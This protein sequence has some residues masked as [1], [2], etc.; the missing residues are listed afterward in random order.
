MERG[1]KLV[2]KGTLAI[3]DVKLF[4]DY[5]VIDAERR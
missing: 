5:S 4:T 3:G 2:N 1:F